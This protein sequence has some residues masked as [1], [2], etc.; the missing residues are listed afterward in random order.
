M[1]KWYCTIN[2][3][4]FW[5]SQDE[6][7]IVMVPPCDSICTL[8]YR[9]RVARDKLYSKERAVGIGIW[10][11]NSWKT[12]QDR[13][14]HGEK[15]ETDCHSHANSLQDESR[16]SL[17]PATEGE[18]RWSFTKDKPTL[19]PNLKST[20]QLGDFVWQQ[21]FLCARTTLKKENILS[22]SWESH[23]FLDWTTLDTWKQGVAAK[24]ARDHLPSS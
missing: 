9:S 2:N 24:G 13:K 22:S 19:L 11:M 4:E 23:I 20:R 18:H 8:L 16:H 6:G 7:A 10:V 5:F 15:W 1:N 3:T 17:A 21:I 12:W 14:W